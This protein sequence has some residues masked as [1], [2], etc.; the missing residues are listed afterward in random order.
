MDIDAI[1][2]LD[3]EDPNS[4]PIAYAGNYSTIY[5]LVLIYLTSLIV[6]YYSIRYVRKAS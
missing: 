6:N 5:R 1:E 4:E 3:P 2:L